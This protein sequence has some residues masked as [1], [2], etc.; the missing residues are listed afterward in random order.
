MSETSP[1]MRGTQFA[2]MTGFVRQ[3]NIPAYAGNTPFPPF[4]ILPMT[5][6]PRVCGE[7]LPGHIRS[8]Y[9]NETSPRMRGTLCRVG[10][11]SIEFRN[12]PAYA[13]NTTDKDDIVCYLPKHPRVCGEHRFARYGVLNVDRNI[14]AYAGNTTV[15]SSDIC[16]PPKHPRVCGEHR[17]GRRRMSSLTRNIPAYAGNTLPARDPRRDIP[18]HPRVCGEHA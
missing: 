7:H 2:Y 10:P 13:G 18:K 4:L 17:T 5:K 14:P 3:R 1:R 15:N 6:H 12:I 11:I 8:A 9:T 16:S